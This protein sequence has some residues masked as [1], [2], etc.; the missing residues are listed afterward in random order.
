MLYTPKGLLSCI[1]GAASALQPRKRLLRRLFSPTGERQPE[2]AQAQARQ[3]LQQ[4][5]AGDAEAWTQL[6]AEWS[7]Q[8]YSYL[9]VRLGDEMAA[10][11]AL[12]T[13][14]TQLVPRVMRGAPI[15]NLPLLILT[16]AGQQGKPVCR[17]HKAVQGE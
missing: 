4:L 11:Q 9:T 1:A 2:A 8:L 17:Q 15:V 12:Q 6:L 5:R 7:P 10:Q 16:L 13:L 3:Q 14:F